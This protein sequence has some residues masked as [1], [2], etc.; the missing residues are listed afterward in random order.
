MFNPFNPK[1]D[2]LILPAVTSEYWELEFE[3]AYQVGDS[4]GWDSQAYILHNNLL[5]MLAYEGEQIIKDQTNN[6]K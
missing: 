1:K 5:N 2:P 4:T 3:G 6:Q